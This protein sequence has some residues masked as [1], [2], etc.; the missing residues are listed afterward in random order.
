MQYKLKKNDTYIIDNYIRSDSLS[1]SEYVLN[2]GESDV[3]YLDWKWI[4]SNNDVQI[5][6]EP[7]AT[8]KLQIEVK[9]E[10]IN[11]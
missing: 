9:A 3:Y 7:D 10:S 8:Y 1:V 2:S 5:G 6:A 11:G 4:S